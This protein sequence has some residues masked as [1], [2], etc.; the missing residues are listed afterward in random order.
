M[1]AVKINGTMTRMLV[2]S[3]APSTLLGKEQ[4]NNLVRSGLRAILMP[5]ERN[6]GVYGNGCL[7]V[8]S[9]F[10]VTIECHGKNTGRR[11]VFAW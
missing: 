7:P 3:G 4:F 5:E 8:V 10:E 1:M 9:K 11:A 6:L 2:D